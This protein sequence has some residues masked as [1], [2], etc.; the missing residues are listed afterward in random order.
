MPLFQNKASPVH[1][2]NKAFQ[3][4]SEIIAILLDRSFFSNIWVT[5]DQC[6]LCSTLLLV[7]QTLE[8]RCSAI[9]LIDSLNIF[10]TCNWYRKVLYN[11]ETNLICTSGLTAACLH[12]VL[13]CTSVERVGQAEAVQK[14]A[15]EHHPV[16]QQHQFL[17][18]LPN[19]TTT[20][21]NTSFSSI[22]V[23]YTTWL[24]SVRTRTPQGLN[25]FGLFRVFSR[26]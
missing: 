4:K 6:E 18:I 10:T 8:C 16:R 15:D 5:R 9:P 25:P 22:F 23:F 2:A 13:L 19:L 12:F 7:L 17:L 26:I 20:K 11:N 3:L 21:H 14:D 1:F 24:I